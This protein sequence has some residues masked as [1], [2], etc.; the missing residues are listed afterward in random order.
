[1]A[2]PQAPAATPDPAA[3]PKPV[4]APPPAPQP[5]A[6]PTPAAVPTPPPAA[7]APSGD[8]KQFPWLGD[9]LTKAKTTA[10]ATLLNELGFP[11]LEAA[12]KRLA[13]AK[14]LE[15]AQLSEAEKTTKR[16]A[17]LEPQAARAAALEKRLGTIAEGQFNAL[18]AEQ[19]TAV[20][21]V[22]QGDP[23][24]RLEL[25][26]VL[27]AAGA[28]AQPAPPPPEPAPPGPPPPATTTPPGSPPT[29]APTRSK[30]DEW[31]ALTDPI[32]KAVFLRLNKREIDASRPA[33]T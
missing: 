23:E 5:Q 28:A 33:Q 14:A 22:A 18:S 21:A 31:Q 15:D 25:I 8:D 30:W 24:K 1:M 26:S 9:R 7:P 2:E 27:A 20:D 29:P 10:Q 6:S 4:I 11:D 3:A 16:L 19:Q 13:E 12:K 17:E 32:A